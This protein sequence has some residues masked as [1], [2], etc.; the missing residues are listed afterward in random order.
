ML[1][2]IQ[3]YG[4][5]PNRLLPPDDSLV[6]Y[7]GVVDRF[8]PPSGIHEHD[9]L[10]HVTFEDG[11]GEEYFDNE[12]HDVMTLFDEFR[13]ERYNFPFRTALLNDR[14]NWACSGKKRWTKQHPS[15]GIR[16][17]KYFAGD[18][19]NVS[20]ASFANEVPPV[21][22]EDDDFPADDEIRAEHIGTTETG[23]GSLATPAPAPPASI[24]PS[25]LNA[26][27]GESQ[28]ST[29]TSDSSCSLES[30]T[31][32]TGS[33]TADTSSTDKP[34]VRAAPTDSFDASTATSEASKASTTATPGGVIAAAN[35]HN[36]SSTGKRSVIALNIVPPQAE[37]PVTVSKRESYLHD[38]QAVKL[39]MMVVETAMLGNSSEWNTNSTAGFSNIVNNGAST[40]PVS[41]VKAAAP[42]SDSDVL[43]SATTVV[44]NQHIIKKRR[45]A[46]IDTEKSSAVTPFTAQSA[47]KAN[48]A[49]SNPITKYMSSA[50]SNTSSGAVTPR[51]S[52]PPRLKCINAA[53][54]QTVVFI[55]ECLGVMQRH[56]STMEAARI[57][58]LNSRETIPREFA[59]SLVEAMAGD[60]IQ[61]VSQS[62]NMGAS[63]SSNKKRYY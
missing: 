2:A 52:G 63:D 15:V 4:W 37:L 23:A 49:P 5:R 3:S 7:F 9:Q 36:G 45:V 58:A 54:T 26:V 35:N 20:A 56:R 40:E 14:T 6:P 18:L 28:M 57:N 50:G 24:A 19:A 48:S 60:I 10:Y 46:D 42:A 17:C 44:A 41:V 12:L 27:T 43:S 1:N 30:S 32:P 47:S 53:N 31:A 25:N 33:A 13:G 38:Q 62:L 22:E 55:D 59:N 8:L 16:V 61:V 51:D 11:D 21:A 29:S 34:A 39:K